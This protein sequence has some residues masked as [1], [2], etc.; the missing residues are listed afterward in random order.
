MKPTIYLAQP[1]GIEVEVPPTRFLLQVDAPQRQPVRIVGTTAE[2]VRE[3]ETW[4][5][6]SDYP[7][8]NFA[9]AF[10][11]T[12]ED[13]KEQEGRREGDTYWQ[14]WDGSEPR[15]VTTITL[16]DVNNF[17]QQVFD[18]PWD[19]IT[20][21]DEEQPMTAA[22]FRATRLALGYSDGDLAQYLDVSFNSVRAWD[23]QNKP[24]PQGVQADLRKLR[25]RTHEITQKAIARF[26]ERDPFGLIEV[27]RNEAGLSATQ[28]AVTLQRW[29][30]SLEDETVKAAFPFTVGWWNI[31]A[32]RLKASC[33][34]VTID[35]LH[36]DDDG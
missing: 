30:I 7:T 28:A 25:D 6:G 34:D 15:A 8:P 26:D 35:W 23:R 18:V 33:P 17:A 36:P 32:V 27:P 2:L 10:V 20:L 31:L 14:L 13:A 16:M 19:A 22:E 29:G 1:D 21:L 3:L 5:L 11:A 12:A 24:I 4:D 9:N